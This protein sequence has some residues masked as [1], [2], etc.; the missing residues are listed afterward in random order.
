MVEIDTSAL[1]R[2][3]RAVPGC[4]DLAP[5]RLQPLA[6]KGL[7]HAHW[8]IA[9]AGLVVRVPRAA[10]SGPEI[11][12]RLARQAA[13]FERAS[14]SGHAPRLHG[15]L[16]PSELLPGGALVV[17]EVAGHPPRLPQDLAL[18]AEALAALHALPLPSPEEGPPLAE[19]R[20]PFALAVAA[21]AAVLGGPVAAL[22]DPD[23]AA[24]L[25][26]ELEWLEAYARAIKLRPPPPCTLALVD[27]HPGNFLIDDAPRA[28]FVD[29]EKAQYGQPA[30]DVAHAT[31]PPS[32]DWDPDC[33][34][35]LTSEAVAGFYRHYLERVGPKLASAIRPWLLPCRR[36]TW[37]R[38]TSFFLTWRFQ[39]NEVVILDPRMGAH[40][41]GV[42][43]HHLSAATIAASRAEWLDQR[44]IEP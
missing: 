7:T 26:D 44:W 9:G 41:T 2:A 27:T 20:D 10:A 6:Q 28:I 29:L 24:A 22:L 12:A 33:A 1:A 39:Q 14:Q 18:I 38:T 42:V 31:L 36:L 43:Q 11:A 17:D 15:V 8:R 32:V 34:T 4:R 5:E 16:P 19:P 23:V 3:L 35:A 13:A 25:A 30:I 40:V 37:L 21:I